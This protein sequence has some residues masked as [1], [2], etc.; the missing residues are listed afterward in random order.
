MR[1]P[2]IFAVL[3]AALLALS[4]AKPPQAEIDAARAALE[5]AARSADV[6]TYALDSLRAAQETMGVL[7]AELAAQAKRSPLGRGYEKAKQLAEAA[8]ADAKAAV[9]DAAAA[10][11]VLRAAAGPLIAGIGQAI[12]EVEKRLWAARRVRG[13]KSDFLAARARDI[14]QARKAL[15]DA[16]ADFD[17]GSYAAA[18]AKAQAVQATLDAI[19]G[20]IS[21]AVRL[22]RK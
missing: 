16:Q 9:A 18:N 2:R 20:R 17:A 12:P 8:L 22:A 7:Q 19:D 15:A 13:M 5:T 1:R 3:S 10:K 11:S 4:C 21:E 6:V 14:A